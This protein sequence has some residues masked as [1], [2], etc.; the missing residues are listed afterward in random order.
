MRDNNAAFTGHEL[1]GYGVFGKLI[2]GK[3]RQSRERKK[4]RV[5]RFLVAERTDRK[6]LLSGGMS[7][8][9]IPVPW[10]QETHRR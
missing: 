7:S 6:N 3:H 5:A 2:D 4:R 9:L 10:Q 8:L 1:A